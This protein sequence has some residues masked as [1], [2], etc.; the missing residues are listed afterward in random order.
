MRSLEIVAA[1]NQCVLKTGLT[2]IL[3]N[4]DLQGAYDRLF[5]VKFHSNEDGV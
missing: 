2:T 5:P 1:A 4:Y 3:L